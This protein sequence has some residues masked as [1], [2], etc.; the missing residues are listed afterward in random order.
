MPP[1]PAIPVKDKF[2]PGLAVRLTRMKEVIKTTRPHGHKR[3][4][5]LIYLTAGAGWH[6]IDFQRYP[7]VPHTYYLICPGQVHHWE[8]SE[9]PR[10]YV[11]MVKEE[12]LEQHPAPVALDELPAALTLAPATDAPAVWELMAR[13]YQQPDA[14]HLAATLAAYLHVLLVQLWRGHPNPQGRSRPLPPLVQAYKQQVE[15][16]YPRLHLVKQYAARLGVTPRYLNMQC[17]QALGQTASHVIARRI[18][19]EAKR[20]LLFTQQT[21][22]QIAAALGFDD[23][24]YFNKFYRQQTGQ[25]PGEYRQS[26]S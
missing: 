24:S 2:L 4:Y 19:L 8:L 11:L 22:A 18:V 13:E 23:P 10:G 16:N 1:A 26:I 20:Q 17:Q 3:Y 14:P 9:V 6:Y 12:F 15:E 25:S 5:E 21:V 7:V